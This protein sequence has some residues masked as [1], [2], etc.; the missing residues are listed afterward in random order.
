MVGTA[1]LRSHKCA[2]ALHSP[3]G[4]R[5]LRYGVVPTI[6]HRR[7][8][9]FVS[10]ASVIDVGANRGQFTL[11]VLDEVPAAHVIA[12]EPGSEAASTFRRVVGERAVLHEVALGSSPGTASL[13]VS[14]ADDSSSLLPIGEA[15]VRYF[16][17]TEERTVVTIDVRLLDDTVD[18]STLA[19]PI[20]LKLDV[21]GAEVDVLRGATRSLRSID[22]VYAEVSFVSMYDGQALASDVADILRDHGFVMAGVAN[23]VS[24][25]DTCL[26]A[27]VLFRRVEAGTV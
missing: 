8:V 22:W 3:L 21:Q 13:H 12:F 26:Q 20:L 5:A 14:H 15:Q 1:V 23:V 25:G 17:G 27:D 11:T 10:P 7:I 19:R 24:A 6:E 4:R 16:P 2:V 9:R 18:A